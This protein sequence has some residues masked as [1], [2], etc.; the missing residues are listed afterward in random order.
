[1]AGE[2]DDRIVPGDLVNRDAEREQLLSVLEDYRNTAM[3]AGSAGAREARIL[4]SG[5]RGVG[6]SI[7]TRKVL[8]DFGA[9]HPDQVIIATINARGLRANG[10][11]AEAKALV[12]QAAQL[13]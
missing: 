3:E 4:I 1:M 2:G 7:L 6:K 5:E 11:E 12:E 9:R 8:A 10:R 13:V